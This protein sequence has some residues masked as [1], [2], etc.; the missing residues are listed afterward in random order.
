MVVGAAHLW[1]VLGGLFTSPH[2]TNRTEFPP[3]QFS[4]L[5]LRRFFRTNESDV[6][7]KPPALRGVKMLFRV[8]VL[9]TAS[10]Y[11]TVRENS[12]SSRKNVAHE[13][14]W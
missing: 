3:F 2:R 1:G 13:V 8:L 14:P 11:M 10:R 6:L 7:L 5:R 9:A 4:E 12:E